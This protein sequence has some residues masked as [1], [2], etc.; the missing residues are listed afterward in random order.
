MWHVWGK[1]EVHI[2]FWCGDLR[3]RNDF[4]DTGV[5]GIILK[6]TSKKW[7]GQAWLS[8]LALDSHGWRA[9]VNAVTNFSVQ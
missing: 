7:D 9:V 5:D 6:W 3:D 8:D 1:G 4:Q 2:G